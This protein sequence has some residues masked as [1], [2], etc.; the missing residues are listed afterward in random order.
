MLDRIRETDGTKLDRRPYHEQMRA[1]IEQVNGI[2]WKLERSQFF[3][4]AADDPAWQAF[5]SGDWPKSLDV[6][7]G[8]RES[9]AAEAAKYA[10][11]GSRFCRMR[12]VEHPI[13]AYVQW[14]MHS[15]K[16]IDETGMPV[17]VLAASAVR[18]LERHHPPTGDSHRRLPCPLRS[19][20]R[21]H[22][23][24]LRGTAH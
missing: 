7:E 3:T 23:G 16:I 22:M 15:L 2:A 12:V 8:E 5:Q 24:G 9:L 13:S 21:R 10:R 14:E 4:E 11:Q 6:F 20:L 19:L 17:R 18:D 1:E